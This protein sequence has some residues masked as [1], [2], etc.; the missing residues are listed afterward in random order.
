[1]QDIKFLI[2]ISICRNNWVGYAMIT[3]LIDIH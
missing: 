3:K 1:M 2:E